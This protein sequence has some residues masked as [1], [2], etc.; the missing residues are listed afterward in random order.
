MSKNIIISLILLLLVC[1]IVGWFLGIPFVLIVVGFWVLG[2][3]VYRILKTKQN[4]RGDFLA[5]VGSLFIITSGFVVLNDRDNNSLIL[6]IAG[7]ILINISTTIKAPV[8]RK[9]NK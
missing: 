2:L 7:C 8:A 1:I 4:P 3:N 5:I 6:I 9:K